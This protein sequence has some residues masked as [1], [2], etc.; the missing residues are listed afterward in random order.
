MTALS[1]A[2]NAWTKRTGTERIVPIRELW[3]RLDGIFSG[4]WRSRFP[5]EQAVENWCREWAAG[6]HDE[7]VTFAMVKNGLEQLRRQMGDE[8][9][10][11]TLPEFVAM[12][13][14]LP[15]MESAF[16]EAQL[17]AGAMN[18]DEDV[19]SHPAIYWAAVDFG[20]QALRLTTWKASKARWVRLLS[21]RLSGVCSPVPAKLPKPVY[22]HE[23]TEVGLSALQ[24]LR[25]QLG[26]R[27]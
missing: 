19:W 23:R 26:L 13:K 16:M 20:M 11:P 9:Y 1:V 2:P 5:D 12:C 25:Q 4:Q 7:M 27:S 6:L 24:G 8:V 3:N 18:F 22:R 21:A 14:G 10:P 15:D 17:Q